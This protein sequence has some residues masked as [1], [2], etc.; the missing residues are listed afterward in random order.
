LAV[1]MA[2]AVVGGAEAL[3]QNP[4]MACYINV[5]AGLIHNEEALQK[6]MFLAERRLPA[7]YIPVSFGGMN[8]PVTMA[9]CMAV[10][11]AG[12]LLGLVLSQLT[13]EGASFIMPG[14]G[15]GSAN[16]RTMAGGIPDSWGIEEEL[17][18]Y[19]GLPMF[20][21]VGTNA[22]VVDQQAA[23]ETAL[24][25][26]KATLSG[27]NIIHDMGYMEGGLTGS[28]ALLVMAHELIG[29]MRHCTRTIKVNDETLALDLIDEIGPLG[30]FLETAHTLGHYKQFWYPRT[31]ELIERQKYAGWV[32]EGSTTLLE[33]ATARVEEILATHQPDPLPEDTAKA[34]K[35]VV[36]RAEAGI[37]G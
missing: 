13:R 24:S 6:L 32:R 22:K 26:L 18:H 7:L 20:G 28:L 23:Q 19:Y 4:L 15:A 17:A 5:T 36:Q 37:V 1:E 2:E 33:R 9:G 3:T 16:M 12:V 31:P 14:F 34:I 35:A 10:N 29:Y 30:S 8:A 25:M 11:N 21:I 27:A